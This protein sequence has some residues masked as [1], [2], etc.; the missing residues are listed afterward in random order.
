M[1]FRTSDI[2]VNAR[3]KEMLERVPPEKR[4]AAAAKLEEFK[5]K[6]N[7]AMTP[8]QLEQLEGGYAR[9]IGAR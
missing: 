5:L 1:V 2:D 8:F 3:A 7:E 4:A 9:T 6:A